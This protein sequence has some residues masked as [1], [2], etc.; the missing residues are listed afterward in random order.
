M[1]AGRGG[2]FAAGADIKA[3]EE[4]GSADMLA[5]RMHRYWETIAR[6]PKP[7]IAAVEGYALGGGCELAMHADIIVA[8]RTATFGQPEIKLG[9]M[10]G[11]GGTQ[12][13]LR[14]IGKYKTMML[15]L[16]GDM[17]PAEEAGRAGLVSVLT[18]EGD[19]VQHALQIA[20]RI[21]RMPPLAAAQIKEAVVNGEDAP[22]ETALR[23]E[24]KAFQLLFDTADKREGIA[25]FLEKRKPSFKWR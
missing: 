13:L 1:I 12:R 6:C 7:V 15:V 25:A 24:R 20:A 5:Q 21:A 23:L 4:L 2:N 8:A 22:L 11:A 3:F 17:F 10:P 19:A 16:T 18:P 9:L 14:A